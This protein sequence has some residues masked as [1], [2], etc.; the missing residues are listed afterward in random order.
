M[1]L[2]AQ[3]PSQIDSWELLLF[4]AV[5]RISLTPSQY[6]LIEDRY[7]QLQI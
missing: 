4:K 2:T 7:S 5:N 1:Y 6:Q 3:D